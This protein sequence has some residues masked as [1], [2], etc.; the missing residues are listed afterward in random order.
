MGCHISP[1]GFTYQEKLVVE[2]RLYLESIAKTIAEHRR[3]ALVLSTMT[4][5]RHRSPCMYLRKPQVF[6]S[7]DG[8]DIAAYEVEVNTDGDGDMAPALTTRDS[9]FANDTDKGHNRNCPAPRFAYNESLREDI[10]EQFGLVEYHEVD[11][12][13]TD[14]TDENLI[15][16]QLPRRCQNL[17]SDVGPVSLSAVSKQSLEHDG[18][19]TTDVHRERWLKHETGK[20]GDDIKMQLSPTYSFLCNAGVGTWFSPSSNSQTTVRTRN[21]GKYPTT[22]IIGHPPQA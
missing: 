10:V 9:S 4:G 13:D 1:A 21:T 22:C 11:A 17:N 7:L 20:S 14:A 15:K 3:Q 8:E 18:N 16:L 12:A 6:Y 19:D 2:D 5:T